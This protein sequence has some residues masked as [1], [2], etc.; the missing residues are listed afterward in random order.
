[1]PQYL[2]RKGKFGNEVTKFDDTDSP[3]DHYPFGS[4]G[5]SCPARAR[6]CKH[7]KIV[8]AWEKLG[9]PV[10]TVFDDSANVIGNLFQ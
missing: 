9:K 7:L 5:C 6:N 8:K 10:G 2:V 3:V 1:M 4:R